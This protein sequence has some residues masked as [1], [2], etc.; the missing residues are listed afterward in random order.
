MNFLLDTDIITAYLR[1]DRAALR[2]VSQN[3]GQLRLS[4]ASVTEVE[5][6]LFRRRA[7]VR[8]GQAFLTLQQYLRILDVTE[9]IAHR[10]AMIASDL[11]R[12]GHRIGFADL[13]I[14]ATALEHGLTLVA[15][16]APQFTLI[17]G[18]LLENWLNS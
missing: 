11:R 5:L 18:L 10:A 3:V 2:R 1:G 6:W 12:R 14:A 17:P 7:P 15:H 4:V 13:Q 8:Y 9:P 16:R